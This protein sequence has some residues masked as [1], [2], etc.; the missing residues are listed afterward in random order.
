M[1]A[2]DQSREW[3]RTGDMEQLDTGKSLVPASALG[4][5]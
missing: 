4:V 3:G 2:G 1:G 5:P